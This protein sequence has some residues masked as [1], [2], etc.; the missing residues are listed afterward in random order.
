MTEATET[1]SAPEEQTAPEPTAPETP[2]VE[3]KTPPQPAQEEK[4]A[5]PR[6]R[7][8]R[9]PKEEKAEEK[10]DPE[11][12]RMQKIADKVNKS[13]TK[14][15]KGNG[16]GKVTDVPR[17][18]RIVGM[19]EE[20]KSGKL[21]LDTASIPDAA[22]R[23]AIQKDRSKLDENAKA[24]LRELGVAG[25]QTPATVACIILAWRGKQLP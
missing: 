24:I 17:V 16:T 5:E 8:A 11:T 3:E 10:P 23:A 12:E 7:A 20:K 13:R 2:P 22:L 18:R 9:K 21:V 15:R 25:R 1:P 6:K 4:K 14:Y 19:I